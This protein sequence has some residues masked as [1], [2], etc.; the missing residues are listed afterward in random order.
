MSHLTKPSRWLR[1]SIRMLFGVV[2][3]ACGYMAC[4]GPTK[5]QGVV[6]VKRKFHTH[7]DRMFD[8]PEV[9]APLIVSS[10]VVRSVHPVGQRFAEFACARCYYFW[11]F[12]YAI[13]L[14]FER[15]LPMPAHFHYREFRRSQFL[16]DADPGPSTP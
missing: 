10:E 13:K 1:V 14:P 4:W 6:D 3:L 12:G 7:P 9:I 2:L 11:C 16:F 5:M 15:D 8:Y